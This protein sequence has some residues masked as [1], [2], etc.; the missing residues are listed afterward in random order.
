VPVED[1]GL[2]N[3]LLLVAATG[4]VAAVVGEVEDPGELDV[5]SA[6]EFAGRFARHSCNLPEYVTLSPPSNRDA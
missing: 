2:L 1:Q 3:K 5:P 6:V 4:E